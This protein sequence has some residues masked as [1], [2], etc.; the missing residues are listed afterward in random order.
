VEGSRAGERAIGVE[1]FP[2]TDA[3]LVAGD[4]I[5]TGA[6][7]RLGG[8][9][10]LPEQRDGCRSSEL[11]EGSRAHRSGDYGRTGATR[12]AVQVPSRARRVTAGT[13]RGKTGPG[14]R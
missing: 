2:G 3:G 8:D 6:D 10:T 1:A 7:E 11:I 4:T 12:E 14:L 13:P 5:E 9:R